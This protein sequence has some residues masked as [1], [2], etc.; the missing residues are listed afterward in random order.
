MYYI[1]DS[2]LLFEC[3]D[4]L[5]ERN[6]RTKNEYQ[7]TD[8]LQLMLERGERMK[9]AQINWL[10]C[11]KPEALLET[12]Q[13]LLAKAPPNLRSPGFGGYPACFHRRWGDG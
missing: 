7:L 2:H 9:A 1:R 4:E 13:Y 10:D 12:N 3:L 11:G 6:I 8:G 5:I